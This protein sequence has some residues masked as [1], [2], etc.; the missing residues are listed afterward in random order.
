MKRAALFAGLLALPFAAFALDFSN[1]TNTYT[2]GPFSKAE[3]AGISVLTNLNA[4]QG[5]PDGTFAPRR[6]VNRAEFLKI[7]FLSHPDIAVSSD[8]SASCFPDVQKADWFSRYVCLAKTRNVVGGYPDGMFRPANTVN[9]A[10]ALK[11]LSNLYSNYPVLCLDD[12][13]HGGC[14]Q[15][16]T[17]E[18]GAPWYEQYVD[19]AAN[20]GLLLPGSPALNTPLTRGQVA[21]LAAS[22]RAWNDGELAEYRAFEQGETISSASS[23]SSS[24]VSSESSSSSSSSLSSSSSVASSSSA[25][26]ISPIFPSTS[27]FLLL[28]TRTQPAIDGTFTTPDED[29]LIRYVDVT[30]RQE[31]K[32]IQSI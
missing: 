7:L 18:D 13:P 28:G 11:M 30:L 25:A 15:F 31:I 21:R 12:N 22:Y 24:S 3:T 4:V 27:R 6:S 2:D 23:S 20:E 1:A 8:D 19:W 16:K 26:S 14:T 5:N 17:Y 9:Y 32:S 10:E 29:G